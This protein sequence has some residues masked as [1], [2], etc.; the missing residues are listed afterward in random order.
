M[1]WKKGKYKKI[2]SQGSSKLTPVP[3]EPK[4]KGFSKAKDG[5]DQ[6]SSQ[7]SSKIQGGDSTT[8]DHITSVPASRSVG[9][10][11]GDSCG[12]DSSSIRRRVSVEQESCNS[13][14]S[15]GSSERGSRKSDHGAPSL[16]IDGDSDRSATPSVTSQPR[17]A[18][19]KRVRFDTIQFR[20][21]ERVVG[22][23]PSCTSG[24]PVG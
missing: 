5:S 15:C 11:S 1:V 12:S 22:D 10:R 3:E 19:N 6:E 9:S 4:I 8:R 24:P 7:D 18:N 21:Y 20:D 17:A 2:D 16:V 14:A 13:A 23:N